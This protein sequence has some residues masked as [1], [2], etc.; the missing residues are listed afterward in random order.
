MNQFL[1]FII[2]LPC[3]GKTS[4]AKQLAQRF[5]L[6]HLSTEQIRAN[7]LYDKIHSETYRN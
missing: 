6:L 4:I 2:G 5:N 1:I 7:I 3:S